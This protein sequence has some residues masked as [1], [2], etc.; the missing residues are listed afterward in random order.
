MI[1]AVVGSG[2]MTTKQYI[3]KSAIPDNYKLSFYARGEMKGL[4]RWSIIATYKIDILPKNV[5]HN[6]IENLLAMPTSFRFH[7]TTFFPVIILSLSRSIN[8]FLYRFPGCLLAAQ[9]RPVIVSSSLKS[10]SSRAASTTPMAPGV[11]SVGKR[12]P[13]YVLRFCL[14]V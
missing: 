10:S 6:T 1:L 5:Y 8:S 14:S 12:H 4:W 7:Q 2:H 13:T 11:K 9:V 3:I